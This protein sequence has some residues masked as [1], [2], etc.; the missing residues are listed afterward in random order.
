MN[1][2][3]TQ[4]TIYQ[5]RSLCLKKVCFKNEGEMTFLHIQPLR[6]FIF[7]SPL[8][9]KWYKSSWKS[10]KLNVFNAL[11]CTATSKYIFKNLHY[12]KNTI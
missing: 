7:G 6:K 5:S 1:W 4:T 3:T 11:N 8:Q 2:K 12:F 9:V 10:Y